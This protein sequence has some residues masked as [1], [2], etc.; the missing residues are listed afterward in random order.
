V[1]YNRQESIASGFLNMVINYSILRFNL[2]LPDCY[3]SPKL[4]PRKASLKQL[5]RRL[6]KRLPRLRK[7]NSGRLRRPTKPRSLTCDYNKLNT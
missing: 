2:S 5:K 4:H 1:F 3:L 7:K 6:S